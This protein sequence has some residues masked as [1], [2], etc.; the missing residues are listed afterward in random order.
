MFNFD[1]KTSV[2]FGFNTIKELGT[3]VIKLGAKN[4]L[5]VTDKGIVQAGLLEKVN[6]SLN[7]SGINVVWAFWHGHHTGYRSIFFTSH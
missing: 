7:A 1:A 3:E 5:A 2:L 4:V 6:E